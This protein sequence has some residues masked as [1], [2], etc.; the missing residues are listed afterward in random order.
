MN[1]NPKSSPGP[2]AFSLSLW[3][4]LHHFTAGGQW[5][6]CVKVTFISSAGACACS[7]LSYVQLFVTPWTAA[8]QA[9]LNFPGKN[10]GARCHFL[11]WG[12]FLTQGSNPSLLCLLHWQVGSLPLAA[13]AKPFYFSYISTKT[14]HQNRLSAGADMRIQLFSSYQVNEE[15]CKM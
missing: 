14:T 15:I 7:V 11:L 4:H 2:Q 13:P 6:L 12:I 5:L 3:C 8:H 1:S 10:T 9:S